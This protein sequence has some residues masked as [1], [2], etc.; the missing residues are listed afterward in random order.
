M[1][2]LDELLKEATAICDDG[3]TTTYYLGFF[4]DGILN[5]QLLKATRAQQILIRYLLKKDNQCAI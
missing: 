5:G 4:D 2:K 3:L 1:S